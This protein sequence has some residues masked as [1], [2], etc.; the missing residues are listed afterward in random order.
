MRNTWPLDFFSLIC[1]KLCDV[2][3]MVGRGLGKLDVRQQLNVGGGEWRGVCAHRSSSGHRHHGSATRTYMHIDCLYHAS[4]SLQNWKEMIHDWQD[5]FCKMMSSGMMRLNLW[6][7]FGKPTLTA[8]ITNF[9]CNC[10]LDG[11][12]L[13][14]TSLWQSTRATTPTLRFGSGTERTWQV[15]SWGFSSEFRSFATCTSDLGRRSS[16]GCRPASSASSSS[17]VSSGTFSTRVFSPTP[18]G[19]LAVRFHTEPKTI[20]D[21]TFNSHVKNSNVTYR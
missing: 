13:S 20:L 2:C 11:C 15:C 8:H 7:S 12:Q 17:W 10:I 19:A 6:I 3:W 21:K 1:C 18:T 14:V 4:C 5:G 16:S 9:C